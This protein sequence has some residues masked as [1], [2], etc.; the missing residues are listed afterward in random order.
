VYILVFTPIDHI[1]DGACRH[2]DIQQKMDIADILKEHCGEFMHTNDGSRLAMWIV[3]YL[4]P[5]VL[6]LSS[7]VNFEE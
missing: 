2:A 6:S 5:K 4:S 1:A 7:L 3:V